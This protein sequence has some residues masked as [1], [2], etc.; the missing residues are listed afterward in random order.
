LRGARLLQQ[1]ID[2]HFSR[3]KHNPDFIKA[4]PAETVICRGSGGN[5]INDT[6]HPVPRLQCAHGRLI[7]TDVG[8]HAAQEQG[9]NFGRQFVQFPPDLRVCQGVKVHLI[10]AWRPGQE[11][12]E[13][14]DN[15]TDTLFILRAAENG[16]GKHLGQP[17]HEADICRHPVRLMDVSHQPFLRINDKQTALPGIYKGLLFLHGLILLTAIIILIATLIASAFVINIISE[18]SVKLPDPKNIQIEVGKPSVVYDR[19][20]E[21]LITLGSRNQYVPLKDI[22]PFLKDA[23][24]A[25]EDHYFYEHPGVSLKGLL[26]AIYV[27]IKYGSVKQG[28]S[29][30]TQQ[31]A[32]TIF[33][34]GMEQHITRKIKEAILAVRLEQRYTKDE[35]L[36]MY[37]N[38]VYLG[39]GFYGVGCA[40]RTYFD[41]EPS[42][43]TLPEAAMLAGVINSPST[44]CPLYN[45]K[46]A[47]ERAKVVLE[48]MYE[49]GYIDKA[50]Y[51]KAIQSPPKIQPYTKLAEYKDPSVNYFLT[52]AIPKLIRKFGEETIYKGGLSIYT[53]LDVKVQESASLALR[54]SLDYFR[55]KWLDGKELYDI[56]DNK[57]IL[58]PQGAI[59][60]IDPKNGDLLAMVGGEDFRIT[61][62]NRAI[63]K[64]QTGSAI[65]PIIYSTALSAFDCAL[66]YYHI[67]HI[68]KNYKKLKNK[69]NTANAYTAQ[70]IQKLIDKKYKSTPNSKTCI[71]TI[72]I[73]DN[74]KVVNIQKKLIKYGFFVGAIRQ[75]SVK[76][77]LLRISIS[78]RVSKK[79]IKKL[80][81]LLSCL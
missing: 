43:L 59:V 64:R 24:I 53:T 71:H 77:A 63:A 21:K 35:I 31:L 75:P 36:E 4:L 1:F 38:T 45:F 13:F 49:Y 15:R 3:S 54:Q 25:V 40:S 78:T 5:T 14:R 9:V 22:S 56:V 73:N 80:F 47:W 46:G 8:F 81:E 19:N 67:K 39:A 50:T 42:E 68:N 62:F 34:L 70:Q 17:N 30:I 12:G 72:I 41:K 18:Y 79:Q 52:Y 74:K 26:R 16:K 65:K 58:Q 33:N 55:K 29:T 44:L 7:N 23:V 28:A 57:K 76:Q 51:E 37:L 48:K 69:L 2:N 60:V 11:L 27:N 61:K 6:P 32:R 66:A 20:G 10:R